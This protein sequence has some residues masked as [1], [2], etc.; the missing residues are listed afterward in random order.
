MLI[1]IDGIDGVGKTTQCGLLQQWFENRG[2]RAL[3]V[4]ELESTLLGRQVKSVLVAETPRSKE[5]ELFAFLCCKS[6]LYVEVVARHVDVGTHVICDRGQASFLSYFEAL[7]FER[8]S[9]SALLL[10]AV[11]DDYRPLTCL[12]D[13]SPEEASLRNVQKPSRSKFDNMGR[14]FFERQRL[15]MNDLAAVNRW[16]M[17]DGRGSVHGVHQSITLAVE[18]ARVR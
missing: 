14:A 11:P 16:A 13:L 10:T 8:G 7:G 15:A 5:A 4:K 9:L 12:I 2:E 6:Q 3:V 17:I 18:N 1:E